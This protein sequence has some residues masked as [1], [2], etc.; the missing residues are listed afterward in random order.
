[1]KNPDEITEAKEIVTA[2][3]Q[4]CEVQVATAAVRLRK[5]QVGIQAALVQLP[6]A[7]VNKSVKVGKLK[8]GWLVCHLI[9][10]EPPGVCHRC[11]G[12]QLRD[13]QGPDCAGGAAA[14]TIK[15]KAAQVHPRVSFVP[16]NT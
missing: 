3:R 7:D 15:H 13:F 10:H 9:L 14:K 1:M 5:C 4:Q 2:L 8:V 11:P 16:R 12:H 6:V